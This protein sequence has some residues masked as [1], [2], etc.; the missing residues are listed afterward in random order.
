MSPTGTALMLSSRSPT[1]SSSTPPVAAT[2]ATKASGHDGS[3]QNC[4]RREQSP[5]RPRP[6]GQK[7]PPQP[8]RRG[9]RRSRRIVERR[10][11]RQFVDALPESVAEG[12][13]HRQRS[14][15]E[16]QRRVDETL[17]ETCASS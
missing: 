5:A 3:Q 10:F 15:A 1:P 9:R 17:H 11:E 14:D 7:P 12:A 13:K 16:D 4:Q 2:L 6:T 8:Q